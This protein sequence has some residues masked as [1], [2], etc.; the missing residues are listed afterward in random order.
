M[1]RAHALWVGLFCLGSHLHAQE[2]AHTRN[3]IDGIPVVSSSEAWAGKTLAF[4]HAA[5]QPLGCDASEAFL[6][7]ISGDAFVFTYLDAPVDEQQR[8][9]WP[10]DVFGAAA[11]PLGYAV[12]WVT[13]RPMDEVKALVTREIDAGHPLLTHSLD[14]R[15][16]FFQI[17]AGY[18]LDNGVFLVQGVDRLFSEPGYGEVA[19]PAGWS[20]AV[21]GETFWARNPLGVVSRIADTPELD[22]GSLARDALRRAV[23]LWERPAFPFGDY[24]E[25]GDWARW[26]GN[27][28][29]PEME[30]PLGAAAYDALRRDVLNA[31][32]ITGGMIWRLDEQFVVRKYRHL[33][34]ARFLREV[35]REFAT[36]DGDTLETVATRFEDT[37]KDGDAFYRM[38]WG[39]ALTDD[40][41]STPEGIRERMDAAPNLVFGIP[42]DI[43]DETFSPWA[44]CRVM[45][46]PWGRIVVLDTRERR[47]HAAALARALKA[48]GEES[49]DL[50]RGVVVD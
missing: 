13:D 26:A 7:G 29:L 14:T 39:H 33:D 43:A 42:D 36:E 4:L 38:F 8:D 15:T 11:G 31:E 34:A 25:E 28:P 5:L 3:R 50:L 30:Q 21:P 40:P 1:S 2:S 49:I 23:S 20:G 24:W 22:R 6:A 9:H 12:E 27:L 37:A 32:A 44:D 16:H 48:H 18:D 17:I 46:H 47:A 45:H 19:I 35:S 41:P 10:M